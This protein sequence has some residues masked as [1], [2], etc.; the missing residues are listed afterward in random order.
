[1]FEE[2]SRD[3]KVLYV[4]YH[5][6]ILWDDEMFAEHLNKI[7]DFTEDDK[8]AES[9]LIGLGQTDELRDDRYVEYMLFKRP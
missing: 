2:Y 1:M 8:I 5:D 9:M 6:S 3:G 4:S 7:W